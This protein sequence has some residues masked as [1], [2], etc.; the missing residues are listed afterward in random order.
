MYEFNGQH[1]IHGEAGHGRF[2]N[3]EYGVGG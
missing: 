2:I 3:R 1:V